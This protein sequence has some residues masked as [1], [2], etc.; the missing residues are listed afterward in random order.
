MF[1]EGRYI[2]TGIQCGVSDFYEILAITVFIFALWQSLLFFSRFSTEIIFLLQPPESFCPDYLLPWEASIL[3]SLTSKRG[4]QAWEGLFPTAG[5]LN[6]CR[7]HSN[8]GGQ[9]QCCS[10]IRTILKRVRHL[11]AQTE[12]YWIQVNEYSG[13][14]VRVFRV[15]QYQAQDNELNC[16]LLVN[17]KNSLTHAL[18][19]E[20]VMCNT[21]EVALHLPELAAF[22]S[23][24]EEKPALYLHCNHFWE[25]LT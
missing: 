7:F 22:H 6:S 19:I 9:Q 24:P 18:D 5:E 23:K 14:G 2:C 11:S 4:I 12:S 20:E 16:P 15:R 25:E 1:C 21:Q 8:P 3:L 10:M 17:T 13:I